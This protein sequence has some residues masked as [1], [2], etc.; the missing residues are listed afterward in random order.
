MSAMNEQSA[1]STQVLEAMESINAST[2]N[3]R[4][5]AKEML[6]SGKQIVVEMERLG[7]NSVEIDNTMIQM[8]TG[9]DEILSSVKAVNAASIHNS[10]DMEELSKNIN[11]FKLS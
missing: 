2:I 1:G 7:K 11:K 3:V 4:D 6:N 9:T 5:G 10:K 8:A